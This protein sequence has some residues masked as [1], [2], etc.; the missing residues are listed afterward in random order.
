MSG[1]G[2]GCLCISACDEVWIAWRWE[3]E[4]DFGVITQVAM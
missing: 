3:I 1:S 2:S 4:V